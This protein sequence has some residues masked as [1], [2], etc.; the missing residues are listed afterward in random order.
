MIP[1]MIDVLDDFKRSGNSH[2]FP[3][4]IGKLKIFTAGIDEAFVCW[5]LETRTF[6]LGKVEI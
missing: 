4:F 2:F 1:K 6:L 3:R 5:S